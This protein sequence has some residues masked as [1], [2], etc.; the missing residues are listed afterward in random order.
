MGKVTKTWEVVMKTK[1]EVSFLSE[2]KNL[3]KLRKVLKCDTALKADKCI[4]ILWKGKTLGA[5]LYLLKSFRG[6]EER[7]FH[8]AV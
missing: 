1:V 3:E 7:K 8:A 4:Y 6:D 5:N 2:R